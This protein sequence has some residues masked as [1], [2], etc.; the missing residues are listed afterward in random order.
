MNTT[1]AASRHEMMGSGFYMRR[2]YCPAYT[3][4]IQKPANRYSRN[5]PTVKSRM[6]TFCG[7]EQWYLAADG[8]LRN[9]EECA[10]EE[11]CEDGEERRIVEEVRPCLCESSDEGEVEH[12]PVRPAAMA[13]A[14]CTPPD[15]PRRALDLIGED[16][17]HGCRRRQHRI[18]SDGVGDRARYGYVGYPRH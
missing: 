1:K 15:T 4:I 18:S 16:C 11:P 14:P 17:A 5:E 6:P 2:I 8:V 12:G 9:V 3:T 7:I 10:D 13:A